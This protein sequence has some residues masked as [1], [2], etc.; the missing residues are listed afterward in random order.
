MHW[1][2]MT[3]P[4]IQ[5][6]TIQYSIGSNPFDSFPYNVSVF[7]YCDGVIPEALLPSFIH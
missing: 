6:N 2:A 3:T 1:A 5:Y 4:S 7:D